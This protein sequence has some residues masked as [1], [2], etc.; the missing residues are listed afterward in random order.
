MDDP[1]QIRTGFRHSADGHL[2][3]A[4]EPAQRVD[5]GWTGQL[6]PAKNETSYRKKSIIADDFC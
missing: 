5:A 1:P 4:F 2:P 3:A 6:S